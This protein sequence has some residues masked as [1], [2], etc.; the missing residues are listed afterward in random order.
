MSE[1]VKLVAPSEKLGWAGAC[2]TALVR[3]KWILAV[4]PDHPAY[5][6]V[7]QMML[8]EWPAEEIRRF[9]AMPAFSEM[10][11]FAQRHVRAFAARAAERDRA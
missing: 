7:L 9:I 4:H 2:V 6:D 10:P 8:S 3:G 11:D 1:L 5:L